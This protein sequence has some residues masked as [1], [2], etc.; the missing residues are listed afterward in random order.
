MQPLNQ[1][2]ALRESEIRP[3]ELYDATLA[4]HEDDRLW[5]MQHR[6]RFV[7]VGCPACKATNH[8]R[9]YEKEGFQYV[10]CG[11]CRTM[12]ITPRP[13]EALLHE[14]YAQ[15][16]NYAHWNDKVFP[17]SED[18]RREKIFKPRAR[19]VEEVCRKY[20]V[21][22]H[23]LLEVGA[24]FGTFCEEIRAGGV[25]ER[26]I[27][28]EP[29]PNLAARCRARGLEVLE[30]PIERVDLGRVAPDVVASFEVIEHL[31]DPGAFVQACARVLSPRGL[32][33]LS[34]PSVRG[35]DVQ[36]LG[37]ASDTVDFEH[38]NYFSPESLG[39]V[40][41]DAGLT[42]LETQTPGKLDAELVRKK[43][44][45]GQHTLSD[46]FLR[47]VLVDEWSELGAPFQDFLARTGL[48][49]HLWVIAQKR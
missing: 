36:T 18:S 20:G 23:V 14:F 44:L 6:A 13:S 24:A 43:T 34:C 27:A 17:A 25:F 49:S 45:A 1:T 46:P 12:Y 40:L 38:L 47:Q 16:K 26:V 31:F 32:L 7:E 5:L 4:A 2:P 42:I 19:R 28:V 29:T 15:S 41:E 33:V 48:S 8:R 21:A 9:A 11:S 37:P 39:R 10:N 30:S 3:D 35:F 22:T